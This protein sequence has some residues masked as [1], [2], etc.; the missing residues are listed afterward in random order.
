MIKVA[1]VVKNHS[2]RE[3]LAKS[4]R[5]DL[6]F[7]LIG[8]LDAF[9]PL[10]DIAR[11]INLNCIIC[12]A[13]ATDMDY[14]ECSQRLK[15]KLGNQTP[16]FIILCST[17]STTSFEKLLSLGACDVLHSNTNTAT[18]LNR[19]VDDIKDE[20]HLML[21]E[22]L[23]R[24]S[25]PDQELKSWLMRLEITPK[26]SSYKYLSYAVSACISDPNLLKN[27]TKNLYVEISEYYNTKPENVE[28]SIRHA[29]KVMW[30]K[31]NARYINELF[32]NPCK[33]TG[34][35]PTNCEL[36]AALYERVSEAHKLQENPK[37]PVAN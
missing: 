24:Y 4:I 19:I 16:K 28:R 37:I 27:V 32:Y 3:A 23:A 6:R 10:V 15:Y 33:A 22:E 7:Q 30:E 36:I 11:T 1:I 2:D 18:L 14:I 35:R 31:A 29:I 12:E 34:K 9:G 13:T 8:S 26:L 25:T 20:S 5:R 21:R 17:L